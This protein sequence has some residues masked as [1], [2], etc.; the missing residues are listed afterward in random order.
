MNGEPCAAHADRT[1]EFRCDGCGRALC[2]DCVETGHRLFFCRHCRERALPLAAD[3]PAATNQYARRRRLDRPYAFVD[4]LAYPFRGLGRWLVPVWIATL[5]VAD[6]L[7]P[8]GAIPRAFVFLLLPGLL[9]SIV[10][11]T[12]EGDDELP[13]WPDYTGGFERFAEILQM[14][15][16]GLATLAP[17]WAYARLTGTSLLDLLLGK[18]EPLA[19]LGLLVALGLGLAL[20]VFAFGATGTHSSGWLTFR[21]D[22]HLEALF[23]AAGP[24]ALRTTG[25]VLA[26]TALRMLAGDLLSPIP[27]LG[28]LASYALGAYSL[29]LSAHFVGLLFRS[30]R[31]TLD[32][33]YRD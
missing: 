27:L 30:H 26:L 12:A 10:R 18:A 31:Q 14:A 20:G 21:L 8:L 17:A 28:A 15:V 7:G 23:S 32:A 6:L 11:T 16:I 33:I 13:D 19:I 25:I 5:F 29:V 4:A 24:A 1:A 9:F 22:L 3:L 2:P